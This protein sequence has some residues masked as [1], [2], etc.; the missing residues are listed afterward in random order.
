MVF[1]STIV[2]SVS[3]VVV[4]TVVSTTFCS[5]RL[6]LDFLSIGSE[7][8]SIGVAAAFIASSDIKRKKGEISSGIYREK[9]Y[10]QLA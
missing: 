5:L 6:F 8:S 2:V 3:L 10:E 1:L 4:A 9:S 7:I